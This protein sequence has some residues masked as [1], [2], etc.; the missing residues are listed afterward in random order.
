[1]NY[2]SSS[3]NYEIVDLTNNKCKHGGVNWK[4]LEPSTRTVFNGMNNEIPLNLS[5][6]ALN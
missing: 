5:I 4:I 3:T 6:C 2:L 1:M